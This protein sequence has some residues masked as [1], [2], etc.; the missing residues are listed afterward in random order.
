MKFKKLVVL[1]MLILTVGIFSLGANVIKIG[2]AIPSA[3]HGW[4]AGV[5]WWAKQ[6]I[7]SYSTNSNIQFFLDTSTGPQEQISQVQALIQKGI[8]ALVIDPWES[9]PLTSICEQAF[10][11]GIYTVIVDRGINSQLYDVYIAGDNYM[12]GYLAGQYIAKYL[13]GKGNVAIIEGIPST[14]NTIR[15]NAFMDAIK[16]YPGIK[17]IADQPGYWNKQ[18]AFT[19]AQTYLTKYS[20]INAIWTGDDDMAQG[21]LLA[22]KQA[23][24]DKNIIVVGGAGSKEI[25]KMIMDGNPLVPVDFTYPPSMIGTAINLAVMGLTHESLNGFYQKSIPHEIILGTEVITK[26]NAQSYYF[27]DSVF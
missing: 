13:N 27:P 22:L 4:T 1:L 5:V 8:D 23:H 3:D 7:S 24:R 20:D 2:V 18:T 6:A 10:K 21:V 14:I 25:V 11:Q 17:V 9:A 12:Y 16:S 19:I 15:V 26:D